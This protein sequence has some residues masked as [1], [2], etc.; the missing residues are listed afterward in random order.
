MQNTV[1]VLYALVLAHLSRGIQLCLAHT[2]AVCIKH[3]SGK[4]GMEPLQ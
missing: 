4:A 3:A 2:G 1:F